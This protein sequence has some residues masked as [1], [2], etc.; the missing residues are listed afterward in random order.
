MAKAFRIEDEQAIFLA[1]GITLSWVND[2]KDYDVAVFFGL[3]PPLGQAKVV[4]RSVLRAFRLV[5]AIPEGFSAADFQ[6]VISGA[7][8]R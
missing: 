2:L 1:N 3:A 8:H 7:Q 6:E 4:D 5:G